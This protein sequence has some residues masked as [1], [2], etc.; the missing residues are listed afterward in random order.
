M[1]VT[2]EF[3]AF[4][5]SEELEIF[6]QAKKNYLLLWDLNEKLRSIAR[7]KTTDERITSE[8]AVDFLVFIEELRD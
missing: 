1:K 7:E 3:D 2:F 6:Q 4:E 5:E 8:M